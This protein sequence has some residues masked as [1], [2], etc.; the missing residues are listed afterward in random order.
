MVALLLHAVISWNSEAHKLVA[1]IAAKL[2]SKKAARFVKQHLPKWG[3]SS[4]PHAEAA[5]VQHA[6]W[7][8][9]VAGTAAYEWS[10]RLHFV[11]TPFQACADYNEDRDCGRGSG[12]CIVTAIA[13]YTQRAASV[14]LSQ[15]ERSEALKFLIHFV[16]DA[17]SGLHVG[18]EADAG[19]NMI[20]LAD[21]DLS[22]HEV[23]D[24]YLLKA[25]KENHGTA[26][27]VRLSSELLSQLRDTPEMLAS[28]TVP[29][30]VMSVSQAHTVAAFIASETATTVTCDLA[31]QDGHKWIPIHGHSL[32]EDYVVS[33]SMKAVD[34]LMRAG[35]RLSQLLNE[36]A[37]TFFL[38]ENV[39]VSS[40]VPTR[41]LSN[42]FHALH[43]SFDPDE[44]V[45]DPLAAVEVGGDADLEAGDSDADLPVVTTI[46]PKDKSKKRKATAPAAVRDTLLPRRLMEGVDV[47]SLVL[48]KVRGH[49]FITSR[50]NL[51]A[52]GLEF[53]TTAAG[54][55][56]LQFAGSEFVTYFVL[57]D[58]VFAGAISV[59]LLE[60]VFAHLK[61]RT[62]A[63]AG[64]GTL[65]SRVTHEDLA[66][67]PALRDILDGDTS[68][69][70]APF[71]SIA[72]FVRPKDVKASGETDEKRI[73]NILMK[74]TRDLVV[75]MHGQ[76]VVVSTLAPMVS[77]SST[78]WV[79]NVMRVGSWRLL[80]DA[81]AIDELLPDAVGRE[82]VRLVLKPHMHALKTRVIA[83]ANPLVR[84]LN[85]IE[86][87]LIEGE[88]AST[89]LGLSVPCRRVNKIDRT[90]FIS[91]DLVFR[92]KSDLAN[93]ASKAVRG[94]LGG[95]A[96]A[97]NGI[98]AAMVAQD[99]SIAKDV[100][101]LEAVV[102][103]LAR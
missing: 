35:V 34:Q 91:L 95:A 41:R 40:V 30:E 14:S 37:G 23:W 72:A 101:A 100:K 90:G 18:F 20:H 75:F 81:R 70:T 55:V 56:G 36:I 54:S 19:G 89:V 73:R 58:K 2:M 33:R 1:R 71:S 84:I 93:A 44:Y 4:L 29:M 57:D 74:E 43:V 78:R 5:M 25:F 21:P 49:F 22:L 79:L 83:G 13:N 76:V 39:A 85:D 65:V 96:T 98:Y 51:E 45:F 67:M 32:T 47:S 63:M 48:T 50:A 94:I 9:V 87:Y 11:D 92:S 66:V 103:L 31:Y 42:P 77:A 60:A 82:I 59:D 46:S 26:S 28:M 88:S 17:H 24:S 86:R 27:W 80:V 3:S 99:P 97:D 102:S 7:A 53:G 15:A 61:G 10:A 64:G 12:Q 38:A 16:A 6:S 69:S 8:D 68:I 52:G 62:P